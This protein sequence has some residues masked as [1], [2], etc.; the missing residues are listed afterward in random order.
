[1][2]G[3]SR[4]HSVER[5]SE[6]QKGKG[7]ALAHPSGVGWTWVG[8][9]CGFPDLPPPQM[10]GSQDFEGSGPCWSLW[11]FGKREGSRAGGRAESRAPNLFSNLRGYHF[12]P[13]LSDSGLPAV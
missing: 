6:D 4:S 7:S 13:F 3:G 8:L 2:A 9:S 1:M 5:I 10:A 11:S 12:Y